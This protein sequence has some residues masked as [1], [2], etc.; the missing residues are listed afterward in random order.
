MQSKEL[1]LC[2]GSSVLMGKQ[3]KTMVLSSLVPRPPPFLFSIC[4]DNNMQKWSSG[5]P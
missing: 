3:A 1:L 4:V 5:I 2:F